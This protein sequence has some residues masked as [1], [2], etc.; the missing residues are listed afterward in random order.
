[1]TV[2]AERT[3]GPYAAPL[4]QLMTYRLSRVYA[5]LNAQAA[6]ILRES[7]GLSQVQWRVLVMLDSFGEI[8]ANQ[9]VRRLL[10]DKGQL[11]RTTKAMVRDG[12]IVVKENESDSRSSL[13]SMTARGRAM[14]ERSRPA[15]R[16]RQTA[17]NQHLT[18]EERRVFL[19]A[20]GKL[21]AAVREFD[22]EAG[23]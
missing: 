6:R 8:T 9:I 13:L 14:F 18:D 21:E 16:A 23:D 11:S 5:Q 15:M 22:P 20:L 10:I 1:M 3:L 2:Q 7:S 12:L 19:A 17:L 4:D